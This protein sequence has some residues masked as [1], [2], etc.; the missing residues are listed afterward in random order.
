VLFIGKAFER[1]GG[2]TLL[3][4]FAL[5]RER[6]P[7]AELWLVTDRH[8][9]AGPGVRR[10]PPTYD[11]A[12]IGALYQSAAIFAM[13]ARCET[14]GDVFLE[15]MAYGL[16]CV[17]TTNNAMPEIIQHGRTGLLVPPEDVGALA[18]ALVALLTDEQL[19]CAMGAQGRQR[20]E[21]MFT[22][23]RVAER[24]LPLLAA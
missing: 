3:A 12:A 5:A 7:R 8:D 11:R 23:S 17:A 10:I 22:W 24:M 14:W 1:K 20:L 19:R 13:P 6:V 9:L 15:A 4:A 21:R 2:D 16:P 18:A